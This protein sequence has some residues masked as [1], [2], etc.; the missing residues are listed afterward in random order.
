MGGM[1]CLL[2]VLVFLL[3]RCVDNP[4]PFPFS[5]VLLLFVSFPF[6]IQNTRKLF[7]AVCLQT[8]R[9]NIKDFFQTI[10][11]SITHAERCLSFQKLV[12]LMQVHALIFKERADLGLQP[13]V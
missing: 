4:S 2:V 10:E 13:V 8:T 11:H 6:K 1:V 5:V 9:A 7:L 3:C 12:L